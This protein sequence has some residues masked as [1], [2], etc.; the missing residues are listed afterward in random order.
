MDKKVSQ[1]G[2]RFVKEKLHKNYKIL[3]IK[4]NQIFGIVRISSYPK[5]RIFYNFP[6]LILNLKLFKKITLKLFI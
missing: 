4:I 5:H 1:N 3:N 6:T 2:T